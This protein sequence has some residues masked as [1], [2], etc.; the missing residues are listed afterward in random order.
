MA[1]NEWRLGRHDGHES[2]IRVV[3]E[4]RHIHHGARNVR[5]IHRG[6]DGKSAIRVR[7]VL[8]INDQF[9][10]HAVVP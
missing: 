8:L 5:G 1:T 2:D 6:F 3:R 10:L 7:N 4:G 9:T